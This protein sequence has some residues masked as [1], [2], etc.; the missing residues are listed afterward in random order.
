MQQLPTFSQTTAPSLGCLLVSCIVGEMTH[1][2]L[3]FTSSAPHMSFGFWLCERSDCNF[4]GAI[5]HFSLNTENCMLHET[6]MDGRTTLDVLCPHGMTYSND[7][8]ARVLKT[9]KRSSSASTSVH[10]FIDTSQSNLLV[11]PP[12]TEHDESHGLCPTLSLL[13][14]APSPPSFSPINPFELLDCKIDHVAI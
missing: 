3:C 4:Q 5:K 14:P 10:L 13:A 6:S 1:V 12:A 11:P 9:D 2:G 8:C 7:T